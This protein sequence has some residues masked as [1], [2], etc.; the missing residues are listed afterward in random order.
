MSDDAEKRIISLCKSMK[1][2]K[3]RKTENEAELSEE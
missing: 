3:Y 2:E 1:D